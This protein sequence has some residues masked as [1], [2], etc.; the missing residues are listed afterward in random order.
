[1]VNAAQAGQTIQ[2]TET[3]AKKTQQRTQEPGMQSQTVQEGAEGHGIKY[4]IQTDDNGKQYVQIDSDL[5][6]NGRGRFVMQFAIYIQMDLNETG[7]QSATHAKEG[8]NLHT[9]STRE[10]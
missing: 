1:M 9:Q 2:Q 10:D 4:S 3:A 5:L 6:K 8:A 7:K